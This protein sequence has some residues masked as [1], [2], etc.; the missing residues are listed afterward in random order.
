MRLS[1]SSTMPYRFLEG[2]TVADVA[3]EARG[4]TLEEMFASAG[5]AVT[6]TMVKDLKSV[7]QTDVREI[8]LE[9]DDV[10]KLLFDFLQ[11]II[12]FKD[13]D[14]LLFTG[15]DLKITEKGKNFSLECSAKGEKLDMEKH[16]LLVD[17]KAVTMHRFEVVK[18][19]SGW[20]ATVILDI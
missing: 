12:F 3:F 14:L 19:K 11:E 6:N 4:K 18:E 5:L 13:V 9:S 17:V 10:E 16:E 15:Y 20:K 2:I 7:S 1:P 8:S